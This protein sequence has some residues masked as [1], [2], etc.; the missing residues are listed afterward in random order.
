VKRAVVALVLVGC[1]DQGAGP[2]PDA[3]AVAATHDAIHLDGELDEPDWNRLGNPRT[4]LASDGS[5]ARPYSQVRLLH[6]ADAL[7]VGLYAADQDIRTTDVFELDV[8]TLHLAVNPSGALT[9]ALPDVRAHGDLD[10]TLDRGDDEDEEWVIEVALPRARVGDAVTR[11]AARRCDTPKDG[12]ER[13]GMWSA[14]ID[15]FA[16]SGR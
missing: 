10:G 16:Q 12:V 13:C 11:F 6:D 3:I 4:F 5:E 14:K 2:D 9:P 15:P 7:Y 8:G 1:R